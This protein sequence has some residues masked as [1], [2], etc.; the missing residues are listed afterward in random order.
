MSE[1]HVKVNYK[2]LWRMLVEKEMTKAELRKHTHIA[3]S[4][5]TK[6]KNNQQV[7]LDILA[8]I[9]IELEC[10]INDIVEIETKKGEI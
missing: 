1:L 5:F 8:R 3:P 10:G 2:P 7:S 4:T 6:M 9:S